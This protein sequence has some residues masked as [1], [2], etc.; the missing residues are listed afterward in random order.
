MIVPEVSGDCLRSLLPMS[1][2]LSFDND[3]Q[4]EASVFIAGVVRCLSEL[5]LMS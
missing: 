1:R 3:C 4:V 2:G 5:D